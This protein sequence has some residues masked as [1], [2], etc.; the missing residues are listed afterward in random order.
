MLRFYYIIAITIPLILYYIFT[1]N[2]YCS[3]EDKYDEE[4]RFG[5]V[6]RIINSLKRVGRIKT[7][8]M[9]EENLPKEGGYI[10]YSNHQGK[11]D[12]LGI[13]YAHKSPCSVVMDAERS[14]VLLTNQVI[15]LVHG[16]RLERNNLKQQ[17]GELMKLTEEV[18]E[19]RRYIYFPEGKYDH[20]GNHLQEFRP[21]AFKCAKM[22][23]VPIV[24]VAIY[25]SHLPF[26]FNS[27]R[28]VTTQVYFLD[29]IYYDEYE[30][31]TTQEIS[32]IVKER[33]EQQLELLE[34]NRAKNGYNCKFKQY[35]HG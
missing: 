25:D 27:L 11:Y 19:G 35:I 22:A 5:L 10:M 14:K 15:N 24:P 23:Q 29:P 12:A 13:M 26:D 9:N 2:Y 20:N 28:K 32:E 31:M 3:H 17:A 30:E 16:K 8:S 7:V 21:G 4:A 34:E 6:L 18:E 1:A 33:I